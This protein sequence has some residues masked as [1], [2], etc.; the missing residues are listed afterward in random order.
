MS[1]IIAAASAFTGEVLAQSADPYAFTPGRTW[2]L[3][4]AG[5]GL[6]GV[7]I[8]VLALVKG[9]RWAFAAVGAGVVGAGIGAWVVSAAEGGPG[10]GYGI[11]G[12]YIALVIGVVAIALGGL[13]VARS[14][15]VTTTR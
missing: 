1:Q 2:S 14:R 7:V 15:R 6:V 5:L 13:A 4:G 10:T 9:G 12:G 8:G 11:V 3:V